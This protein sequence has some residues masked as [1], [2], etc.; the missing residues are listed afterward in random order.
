MDVRRN[1]R[2]VLAMLLMAAPAA[3]GERLEAIVRDLHVSGFASATAAVARLQAAEDR[4]GPD[5]PLAQRQLFQAAVGNFAGL[6]RQAPLAALA[7]DAAAQ[8]EAMASREGCLSCQLDRL[9]IL[10]Q[11]SL[12]QRDTA[13]AATALTDTA[14]LLANASRQQ[15]QW[16]H[17][18]R[19]RTYRLQGRFSEGVAEVV[20][21]TELA[22]QL[23][24][25][26]DRVAALDQWLVLSAYLDDF[27]RAETLG[28]EAY[29]LAESLGNR[30]L[31]A[32]V[33]LNL[34]FAYSRARRSELQ[35]QAFKRALAI[36]ENDPNL[37]LTY[38]I[39][40]SNLADHWMVKSQWSNALSYAGRAVEVSR[41]LDDPVTLVYALT[42]LG[43]AKAHLG[44]IKA[45]VT[46]I[47]EAV[48][49]A[50]RL[51]LRS[52]LIGIT[53]EL[54]GVYEYAGRYRD[55]FGTLRGIQ[56]LQDEI[57]RQV[58]DKAV[59]ELQEKYSAE[60]RQ[61]EIERL[62]D[63]NRIK[64]AQ[65]T[66][67]TWQRRL[68]AVLAITLSLAAIVLVQWLAY[69]R[70]TN[71]RLTDNVAVLAEQSARDPLTGAYNRRQ[72]HRLLA[73]HTE[74]A[75]AAPPGG[76]PPLGVLL[77]DLDHFKQINDTYGHAAGDRVLL[78]VARR[79]GA[80]LRTQDALI[81][82]GG[83]EFLLLLPSAT[84]GA[85]PMLAGLML[86]AIGDTPVAAGGQPVSVSA[87]AGGV[88]SPFGRI[89]DIEALV[90]LADQALYR[91]KASGRNRAVCVSDAAAT[92][93]AAS[94]GDDL[95]AAGAAG[96][97]RLEMIGGP[98]IIALPHAHP[99]RP[100]DRGH[101]ERIASAG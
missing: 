63:A 82:W 51:G 7:A 33:Q 41:R 43:V 12:T 34:G 75:R 91:A 35:L 81:R 32:S 38:A 84:A 40:L 72:G 19:A 61:R 30:R 57:N 55:A 58:R 71:R 64:E 48:E 49:L 53:S 27:D 87:S 47:E 15:M 95:D 101:D 88:A 11:S 21:A 37:Q 56:P 68:W 25:S 94:L 8:L 20:K 97:I 2:V 9:L 10:T 54:V 98:D 86:H 74:A 18:L 52:D 46:S 93:D 100:M 23:G 5:A 13:A 26:A 65:L 45:G 16:L 76:A 73:S 22:E 69:M 29:A 59:L 24:H 3:A 50:N 99:G 79:L 77:L 31:M 78:E 28:H 85:L 67:Q 70:R 80:L 90:H 83:E 4:P 66:A 6:E 39:T 96:L 62:A 36:T 14:P 89:A 1:S 17:H 42:N 44:D 60:R 92:L